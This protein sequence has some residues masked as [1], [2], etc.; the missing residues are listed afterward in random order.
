MPSTTLWSGTSNI[1]VHAM[2]AHSTV[3]YCELKSIRINF[4]EN[5]NLLDNV[6]IANSCG[7]FRTRRQ[8]SSKTRKQSQKIVNWSFSRCFYFLKLPYT[9]IALNLPCWERTCYPGI[10]ARIHTLSI[11]VSMEI[12][13]HHS[14][15]PHIVP[16]FYQLATLPWGLSFYICEI[17]LWSLYVF[18][19]SISI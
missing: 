8:Q 5:D 10:H 16:C 12:H 17:S 15:S 2:S 13:T 11:R 9:Y 4:K 19:Y 14:S 1:P 6:N 3:L 7:K 18:A